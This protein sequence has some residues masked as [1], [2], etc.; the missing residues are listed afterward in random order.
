[1]QHVMS[2]AHRLRELKA[3]AELDEAAWATHMQRLLRMAGGAAWSAS[4][5]GY[6]LDPGMIARFEQHKE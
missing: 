5:K 2:N 1:M 3:L 4:T 6:V